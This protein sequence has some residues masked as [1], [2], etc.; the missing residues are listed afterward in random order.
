MPCT[1]P[2]ELGRPLPIPVYLSTREHW[3]SPV[4]PWTYRAIRGITSACFTDLHRSQTRCCYV[5]VAMSVKSVCAGA[6]HSTDCL[7]VP[8]FI[9][10]RIWNQAH[11]QT[12]HSNVRLLKQTPSGCAHGADIWNERNRLT[13]IWYRA[14]NSRPTYGAVYLKH[15]GS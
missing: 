15:H 13:S 14:Y 8:T 9:R 7:V 12:T 4:V 1:P 5:R 3:S 2:L 6:P 11:D 10:S